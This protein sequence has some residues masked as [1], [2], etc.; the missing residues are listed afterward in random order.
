MDFWKVTRVAWGARLRTLVAQLRGAGPEG[1]DERAQPDEDVEVLAPL[2]L[3][4]RPLVTAT[5]EALVIET[6]NGSRVVTALLDKARAADGLDAEEGETQL[7]GLAAQSAVIRL[8][9]S[10]DIE[11][12]PKAGRQVKLGGAAAKKVNREGDP[13][14]PGTLTVT[15]T[16]VTLT[17]TY[18][19][20]DG[21]TPVS[22]NVGLTGGA[23]APAAF[24]PGTTTL[25]LGGKTGTGSSLVRAED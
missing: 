21:G 1:E 25:T 20:P 2:G 17:I 12:I 10:G 22:A 23:M 18:T 24:V 9:A 6:A 7:H 5:L 14:R 11:V 4:V 13:I 19:P 16:A 8:R 15:A 3:R